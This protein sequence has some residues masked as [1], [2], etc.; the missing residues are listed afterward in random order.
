MAGGF[1]FGAAPGG[2]G[3]AAGGERSFEGDIF[4]IFLYFQKFRVHCKVLLT[5]RTLLQEGSALGQV[6]QHL[7]ALALLQVSREIGQ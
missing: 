4:P 3:T 2:T 6:G 7:Q 1:G 5:R